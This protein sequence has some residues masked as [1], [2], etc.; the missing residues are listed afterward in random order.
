MRRNFTLIELLVVIA[1]IA[2]LAS[3]LL[4]ALGKAREKARGIAC[5]SNLRQSG[6]CLTM[7]REDFDDWFMNERTSTG[8]WSYLLVNNQ[9]ARDYR[10]LRCSFTGTD[11]R[12]DQ[13]NC[14]GANYAQPPTFPGFRL[15][16]NLMRYQG[17]IR[18]S[19]NNV[20]LLGCSRTV[21]GHNSQYAFVYMNYLATGTTNTWGLAALHLIH[22]GRVNGLMY[23]GHVASLSQ[24]ELATG[25]FY[26]PNYE[27]SYGGYV[28]S[29]IRAAVV[30]GTQFYTGF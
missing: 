25:K 29:K 4:P 3:M 10:S 20:L 23:D 30:P 12:K 2:I 28:V 6:L 9:Y 16:D 27:P 5:V 15:K 24:G 17:S 8:T 7:Y 14:Y 19:S 21:T 22:S 18:I 13:D 11:F 1:I 26:F